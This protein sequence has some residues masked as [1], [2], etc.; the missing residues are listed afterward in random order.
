MVIEGGFIHVLGCKM[1][2]TQISH[3]KLGCTT[4]AQKL[5][6]CF[7]NEFFLSASLTLSMI[8]PEERFKHS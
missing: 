1:A 6:S 2:F 8:V 5:I 7:L 4:V 3:Y